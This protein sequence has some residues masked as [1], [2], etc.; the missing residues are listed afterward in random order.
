MILPG[1]L[2]KVCNAS[3]TIGRWAGMNL[4]LGGESYFTIAKE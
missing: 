4:A 2:P 1:A 3:H